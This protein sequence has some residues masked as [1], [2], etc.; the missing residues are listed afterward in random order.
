[1]ASETL[2]TEKFYAQLHLPLDSLLSF[3][4]FYK[5]ALHYLVACQVESKTTSTIEIYAVVINAF[6]KFNDNPKPDKDTIRMFLKQV[7]DTGVSI[8]TQHIYFRTLKTFFTWLVGE[9][10]IKHS[11]MEGMKAPRL[12]KL[13]ITPLSNED[14][15]HL[16]LCTSGERFVDV[17]NRAIIFS[18]LDNGVRLQEMAGIMLSDINMNKGCIKVYGKG[19]KERF[20]PI[21]KRA[22]QAL[23][24][25]I[26]RRVDTYP[27]LWLTEER[28]PLT[29]GGLQIQ[30][31]RLCK[32]A[33]VHSSKR[34]AHIFRHT[35]A[36][37]Y[38][39]NGGD[40]FTLQQILGHATLD[41]TRKYTSSLSFDDALKV[42]Q[43]VSPMDNFKGI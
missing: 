33:E 2:T 1:M 21:G 29:A 25:Y 42:H 43:K 20:V 5:H 15:S 19:H 17:R 11:P 40:L 16:V 31:R 3:K 35:F 4:P 38:L 18:L 26:A 30:L 13:V 22:K 23:L 28:K 7:Q 32:Q 10:V 37:N 8:H 9:K 36:I 24:S 14:I 34:G 6:L 39:R 27:V 41:M 12:P